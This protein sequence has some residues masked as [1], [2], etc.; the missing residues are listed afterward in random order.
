[1]LEGF[2]LRKVL[3]WVV[4][5]VA[6]LFVG[7]QF[8]PT[9]M[10]NSPVDQTRTLEAHVHVTP[11][12]E[13][14]L[15]RSCNDCHTQ[16]TRYPWYS[17]VAP[18]SWLLASHIKEGRDH[19][20]FSDWASYDAEEQGINLQNICRITKRGAMP[21]NSYLYI[22]RDAKLSD[23]DVQTLCNWTNAEGD[24]LDAK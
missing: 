14:I 21:I 20:N 2:V 5:V 19:L 15:A 11:E 16:Q 17:K 18:F 6:L 12:V 9:G 1:M 10:S 8:V 7:V 4:V 13:A 22:H 3:K 23:A 24:K